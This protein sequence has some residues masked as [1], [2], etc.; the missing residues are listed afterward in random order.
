[1]TVAATPPASGVRVVYS[2]LDG[3]M[4]GP[5]GCFFR[6]EST[7]LTLEPARVLVDLLDSGIQLVL[8]SGRTRDQLIEAARIFGAD[9]F[10]GELGAVV[11]WDRGRQV[12][13]LPGD[14]PPGIARAPDELVEALLRRYA[15]R[16]E[17]HAPWHAGHQVDV[18]LRGNVRVEQTES[19]LAAQGF[20][21]LRLRDNGVL[22]YGRWSLD[23]QVGP[24]HVYHLM[25][26]GISKG[27]AV[28]HDLRRRG[29]SPEQAIAIG[30]S[31]S[32]LGMAPK[33]RR[34]W[35]TANGGRD[36]RLASLLGAHP[37]A[38]V[39]DEAVGLGWAQAVRSVLAY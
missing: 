20:P 34:F 35:L 10:I 17:L 33:V 11:G 22:P 5:R 6:A 7:A 4:V 31:E 36:E 3:T 25:P 26:D 14:A 39:C 2:D 8:V 9:G 37:N 24:V 32:D 21:W 15:G 27:T 16:L 29:L 18:L 1:M 23:R 13:V 12:E 38:V 30:D 19:W 28:G